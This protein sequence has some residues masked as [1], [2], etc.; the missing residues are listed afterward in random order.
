MNYNH[1]VYDLYKTLDFALKRLAGFTDGKSGVA[2]YIQVLPAARSGQLEQ[3]RKWRNFSPGHGVGV[4]SLAP[5]EWVRFLKAE[6]AA[7]EK[8]GPTLRR[9]LIEASEKISRE[10]AEKARQGGGQPHRQTPTHTPPYT[11]PQPQTY[12]PQPSG[13]HINPR[14]EFN[15]KENAFHAELEIRNGKG[16]Y[17]EK[18]LF[19]PDKNLLD[20]GIVF[21]YSGKIKNYKVEILTKNGFVPFPV[22]AGELTPVKMATHRMD[23]NMVKVRVSFEYKIGLF[24]TKKGAITVGKNF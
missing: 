11:K 13:G 20:F 18:H 16:R 15:D 17:T 2:A 3:I 23:G 14:H 9:K 21:S 10:R 22:K 1:E 24:A 19:K 5:V 7:V 12:K 8:G 4:Q 6:I